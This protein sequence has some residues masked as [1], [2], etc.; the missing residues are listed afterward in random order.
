MNF[1]WNEYLALAQELAGVAPESP[2]SEEARHRTAINRAY[3]ATFHACLGRLG[4]KVPTYQISHLAVVEY[5]LHNQNRAYK[6]IGT[7]LNMLLL[8]RRKADYETDVPRIDWL[9]H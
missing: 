7:R 6:D 8:D 9:V 3:F 1:D 5:F 2:S 4:S